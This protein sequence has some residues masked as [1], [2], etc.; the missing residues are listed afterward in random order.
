MTAALLDDVA[1]GVSTPPIRTSV[2][3]R[4]RRAVTGFSRYYQRPDHVL[5]LVTLS[6]MLS[7]GGGAVMFWVHAVYRGEQGPAI[8]PWAHWL[9]DSSLGFLALTPALAVLLPLSAAALVLIGRDPNPA[10]SALFIGSAFALVT[11]PGPVVHDLLVGRGTALADL[12]TRLIGSDGATTM[13]H[14]QGNSPVAECLWQ[15]IAGVP[16]Y[17]LLTLLVLSGVHRARRQRTVHHGQPGTLGQTQGG[18]FATID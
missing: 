14:A 5:S 4:S 11:A 9:L 15:V 16:T 13:V 3:A 17:T 6:V 1:L 7:Y 18:P 8:S 12:A 10:R 2:A